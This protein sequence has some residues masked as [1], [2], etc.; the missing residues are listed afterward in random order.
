VAASRH[1]TRNSLSCTLSRPS[2]RKE[3]LAEIRNAAPQFCRW[4]DSHLALCT[5]PVR[6]SSSDSTPLF[7][8]RP[9]PASH[10]GG[11]GARPDHP[12]LMSPVKHTAHGFPSPRRLIVKFLHRWIV[13]RRR[14]DPKTSVNRLDLQALHRVR[15]RLVG[16]RTGVI[17]QIRAFLLERGMT[18]SKSDPQGSEGAVCIPR[19]RPDPK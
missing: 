5:S 12:I 13:Q 14:R 7:G 6:M 3:Q 16:Q 1:Q 11:A 9:S 19:V 18:S 2:Q 17:N 4:T 8:K 10:P 15:D